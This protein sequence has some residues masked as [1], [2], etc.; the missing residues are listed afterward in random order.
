[1]SKVFIEESTLT[2]IGDAIRSKEGTAEL[3]PP[4]EM[5]ARIE[6]LGGGVNYLDYIQ[7]CKFDSLNLFGNIKVELS[8]AKA[9][10]LSGMFTPKYS[11]SA[12]Y[13][14]NANRTVEELILHAEKPITSIQQLFD[15]HVSGRDEALKRVTFNVDFSNLQAANMV[16]IGLNA[17]EVIDGSPINLSNLG[18]DASKFMN[19]CPKFREIRFAGVLSRSFGFDGTVTELSKAS[20]ENI[21]GCLSAEVTGKTLTLPLAAVNT[22]FETSPGAA[23]GSASAEWLALVDAHSNWTISLV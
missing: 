19:D 13:R 16:F 2:G 4:L 20:I 23:D 7:T 9:T 17:L 15:L 12:E 5:P 3:I 8:F 14:E 10:S 6:A 1:M 21:M 11:S 18:A 22:A